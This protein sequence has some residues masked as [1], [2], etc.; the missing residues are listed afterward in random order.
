MSENG[1]PR[2]PKEIAEHKVAM[3][4]RDCWLAM[5]ELCRLRNDPEAGEFVAAHESDLWSIR[6]QVALVLSDIETSREKP[7]LSI[8]R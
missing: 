1:E 5:G 6:T 4:V 8:V 2:T 7:K 3:A